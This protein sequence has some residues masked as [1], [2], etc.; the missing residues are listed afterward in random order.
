VE[1]RVRGR[2]ETDV[3]GVEGLA[4]QKARSWK[5]NEALMLLAADDTGMTIR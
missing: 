3:I 2:I 4:H 5:H 1:M